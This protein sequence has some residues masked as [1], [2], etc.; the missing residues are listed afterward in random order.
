MQVASS[1]RSGQP[2]PSSF[3]VVVARHPSF[4]VVSVLS[5][6]ISCQA[7]FVIVVVVQGVN[8]KKRC[9]SQ[10]SGIVRSKSQKNLPMTQMMQ[11]ASS[12]P[13]AR[14]LLSYSPA[15]HHL[16]SWSLSST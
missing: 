6:I 8:L 15:A 16:S 12:E 13:S 2:M 10:I 9:R 14:R 7:L 3:A 4:V 5:C 1:G 11:V